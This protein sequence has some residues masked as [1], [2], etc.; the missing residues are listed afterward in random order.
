MTIFWAI[1][2][3]AVGYLVNVFYI[4]VA[5][6]RALTHNS[7]VL[8]P[9]LMRFIGRSGIWVTGIDPKAWACMHRMHHSYSDT[10]RDPHS[11]VTLGVF[12]VALGQLRSYEKTLRRLIKRDPTYLAVVDD[13]AFDVSPLNRKRLWTLPY[14]LHVSIGVTLGLAFQSWWVGYAYF[15]GIMSHPIQGWMV[16]SL[17]HKYGYR[18]FSTTDNSKNNWIVSL[19]VFGEGYQNNHHARPSSANFAATRSE[20]DTGYWLCRLASFVGLLT[21]PH[22][23]A[24][25]RGAFP[26]QSE[27]V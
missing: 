11:P 15:A 3:F 19:L 6:H 27:A 17:A 1:L 13:I 16:N 8:K 20:I 7:V 22:E 12:G 23:P 9:W 25:E 14:L 4:T 21:I 10:E 26:V 5:Y 2:I 24:G 18:N